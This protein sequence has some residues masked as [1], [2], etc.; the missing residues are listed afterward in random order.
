MKLNFKS[1]LLI[2]L[3]CLILPLVFTSCIDYVQAISYK[4]GKYH[5][6]YKITMSKVIY[7]M[8][9]NDSDQLFKEDFEKP[10]EGMPANTEIGRVDTDQDIGV[11]FK[12]HIDPKTAGEAEKKLLPKV[13]GEKFFIPLFL[14]EKEN[15]IEDSMKSEGSESESKKYDEMTKAFLS[16]AKCKVIISK[17]IIPEIKS[18][19]FE[20]RDDED[21]SIPVFD[22]G[23]IYCMEIPFI[24]LSEKNKYKL[25]K[26]IIFRP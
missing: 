10:I 19:C 14:G 16:T 12:F 8:S 17:K 13:A 22:Y 6:Y 9:G 4:D 24:V 1:S 21:Y 3:T 20:G 7:A 23:E 2:L 15:P 5:M 11:E 26:I 25:D 18:A